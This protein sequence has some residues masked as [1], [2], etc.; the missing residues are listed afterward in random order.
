MAGAAGPVWCGMTLHGRLLTHL[1]EAVT[2][3]SRMGSGI[4]H[5]AHPGP[6]EEH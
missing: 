4:P 6:Q 3:L 5:A 2:G 1:I